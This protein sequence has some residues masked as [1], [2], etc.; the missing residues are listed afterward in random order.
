MAKYSGHLH[1]YKKVNLSRNPGRKPF[2]V[3]KCIKPACTHYI[4]V[5]LA[6]NKL[7]ECNRCGQTMLIGKQT[8]QLTLVHCNECTKKKKDISDVT[9]AIDEA[10]SRDNS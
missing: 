8:L 10:M 5:E 4:R 7:C 1:K 2:W 3:Y 6:E 9:N